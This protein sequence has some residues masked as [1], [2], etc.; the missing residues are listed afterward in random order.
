MSNRTCDIC[1]KAATHKVEFPIGGHI[2]LP[3]WP[4]KIDPHWSACIC[5]QCQLDL[6][7]QVEPDHIWLDELAPDD[8]GQMIEAFLAER[9][10]SDGGW[11]PVEPRDLSQLAN[12]ISKLICAKW[13]PDEDGDRPICVEL[14]DRTKYE[15]SPFLPVPYFTPR[16]TPEELH[17]IIRRHAGNARAAL[18]RLEVALRVLE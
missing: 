4:D 15:P 9:R 6:L 2:D 17:R 7:D 3:N 11:A 18:S 16:P 5:E 12:I 1:G 8:L 14:T 10:E 13:G